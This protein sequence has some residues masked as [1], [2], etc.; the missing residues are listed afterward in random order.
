[1]S[2]S[3]SE[4]ERTESPGVDDVAFEDV[5]LE[6]DWQGREACSGVLGFG[7]ALS[8]QMIETLRRRRATVLP[9]RRTA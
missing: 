5:E 8:P 4:S 1:M 6:L 2:R 3:K 9:S 7:A